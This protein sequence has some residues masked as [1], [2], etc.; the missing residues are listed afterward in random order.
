LLRKDTAPLRKAKSSMNAPLVLNRLSD[1]SAYRAL[2]CDIWGVLHNGKAHFPDAYAALRRFK[3]EC[4]P[5]ILISNSPRPKSDLIA[6]L[7][8]L[9]VDDDAYSDI[10]SSGDATR[11]Y[12]AEFSSQ[13]PAWRIGDPREDSLYDGLGLDLSGTPQTAAF[14]SC[15]S[16]FDDENDTVAQYR[17]DFETAVARD[18]TM[19]CAN[20]DRVVH[21]GEKLI[22]CAGS[23]AD[24][25]ESLGGRVIMAGKPYGPIYAL[26][27]KA[28]EEIGGK[29]VD[30]SA[31]L[32]IGDG[33]ITDLV[34]A[35]NQ[36]LDV[37]FI[38]AGISG[39]QAIDA[40]GQ[41]IPDAVAELLAHDG[42]K[43]TFVA[44]TLK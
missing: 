8:S 32:A 31:I 23:L 10:V 39:A 18:L 40:S 30:K 4:G 37:L 17:A 11:R 20:P 24:F 28:L 9:G 22:L 3:A 27:Y 35:A 41:I 26:C 34:G 16:P 14:I 25:Y 33:I 44:A 15:T 13:G 36:G 43:A 7:R 2:L 12:L 21:R 19:I 38:A 29:P 5:V 42:A 6:Q 1:L